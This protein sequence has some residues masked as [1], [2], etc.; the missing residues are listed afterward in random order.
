MKKWILI[1]VFVFGTATLPVNEAKANP[2]VIIIK[3]AIKKVLKA[4]DLAVQR[5][6]NKTIALQNAQKA[7]ENAMSK[8]QLDEITD[9]VG[10]Q[11]ELYKEY[12]DELYKVKLIITYYQRIKDLAD[13]QLKLVNAYKQSWNL[14]QKDDHF[15]A[16]EIAY[17]AK[18]YNGI[19]EQT[20]KDVD[21]LTLVVN[22]FTT[23]MS[24]EK[25]LEI[26]NSAA[27]SVDRNYADLVQFNQ[28]N[29]LL[30]LQRAKVLGEVEKVK[31][32]YGLP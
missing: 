6:Q 19:L 29:F 30:S 3:A 24:D 11:K 28:Q 26:I 21:Q 1:I 23:Q 27:N 12:Y 10:K 13:K 16:D 5:L 9:W 25:R 14:L 7:L 18:V 15:S 31:K 22:A 32:L 20:A 2:I 8:L 17:M 4:M